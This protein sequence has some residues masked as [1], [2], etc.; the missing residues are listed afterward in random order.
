MGVRSRFGFIPTT[1]FHGR[2]PVTQDDLSN[3][4][5]DSDR[6]RFS[7][8]RCT[9]LLEPRR[10]T[11]DVRYAHRPGT[12]MILWIAAALVGTVALLSPSFSS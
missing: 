4:R 3:N 9:Q 6:G 5:A 8:R 1:I 11:P 10:E 2:G 12:D 7:R